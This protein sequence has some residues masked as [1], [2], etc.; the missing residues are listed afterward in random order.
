MDS[1]Q[2]ASGAVVPC[3]ALVFH[4]PQLPVELVLALGLARDEAGFVQVDPTTKES[5]VPGIYVVGDTT[6]MRQAAIMAAADGMG[7]ATMINHAR[8]MERF[9]VGPLSR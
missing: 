8:I 1:V 3:R 2:L 4:P 7:A 5:S 9:A 6:T